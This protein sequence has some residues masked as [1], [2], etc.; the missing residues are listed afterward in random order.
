M[1]G[2]ISPLSHIDE[3]AE[4][5]ETAKIYHFTVIRSDVYIGADSII[6]HSV[7]IE[8]DTRIGDRTTIQSQ[9]HITAEA[10]IGND[11]FFGPCVVTM[12]ERIV[13]NQG[14]T[15]PKIEK[16]IVGNGARIGAGAIL[17]PGVII[18]N[19]ASI[20]A[21]SFVTKNVPA[22]EIWGTPKGCNRAQKV[23]RVPES[24]WL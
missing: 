18:G 16:L 17:A 2:F 23:G 12:N 3:G 4:I 9:C 10:L 6:G 14:R 24:E 21:G 19:N 20:H 13:A 5:N 7:V 8:R 15:E 1:P 22:G 11:C